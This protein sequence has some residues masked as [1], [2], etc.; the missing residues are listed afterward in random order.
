MNGATFVSDVTAAA[1]GHWPELLANLGV[2]VP[3]RK[4]HGPCPACGGK[5]RFRPMTRA[6]AVLGFVAS[7]ARVT[8]WI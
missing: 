1:C 4:Q 2:T 5:D 7:V 8:G 3:P 6:G